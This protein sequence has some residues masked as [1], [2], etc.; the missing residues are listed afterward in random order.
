[1]L[2]AVK[3]FTTA[4]E[5]FKS[6]ESGASDVIKDF[7]QN[8]GTGAEFLKLLDEPKRKATEVA[9]VF[10]SLEEIFQR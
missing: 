2:S 6:K 9:L 7:L 5:A 4:V 8:G 10:V 3:R 1:M